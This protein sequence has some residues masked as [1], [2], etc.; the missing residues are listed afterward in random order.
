MAKECDFM[1]DLR[2]GE[3]GGSL[4]DILMA[5]KY[6]KPYKVI[7][8]NTNKTFCDAVYLVLKNHKEI[9]IVKQ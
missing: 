1:L 6:H 8:Y 9:F 2:D 7:L 5:E 3:S 4:H